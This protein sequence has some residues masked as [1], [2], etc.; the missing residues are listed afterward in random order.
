MLTIGL[1]L[2][3]LSLLIV[4]HELGHFLPAK[5]FGMRVEKFYLFFDWPTRLLRWRRGGTEY[6]IGVLPLGGYVKIAGMVD[7][8][9]L[10]KRGGLPSVPAPDEFR[11]KP[12]HQRA[13]V[14]AGGP[15]MN[16]LFAVALLTALLYTNGTQ[17]VPL[18]R[19]SMGMEALPLVGLQSGDRLLAVNDK[20]AYLDH[21]SSPE[22]LLEEEPV[23]TVLRGQDTLRITLTAFMRDSLM[24]L[25]GQ[26]KEVFVPRLPAQIEPVSGGPAARAGLQKGDLVVSIE[27]EPIQSFSEMRQVLQRLRR[28]TV[29][30]EVRRG[31]KILSVAVQLDTAYRLQAYPAVELP[32]EVTALSLSTAFTLAIFQSYHLTTTNL[33]ALFHLITGRSR[34]SDSV[35]GPIGIAKIAG[36]TFETSGW[37][38]FWAFTA[39]LSLI[40]AIMNLLPIPLLDG[41]HLVFLGLE[42]VFRRE[43][44]YR[45]REIAQYVGLAFIL[46]LMIFAFWNDLRRL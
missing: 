16:I 6:G 22:W 5:L 44:S 36:R 7:E 29:R 26:G 42:A 8:S 39:S 18:H 12:L 32:R 17:R 20:A 43:P 3:A 46:A 33:K 30:L 27:G 40:L 31:E 37:V 15:L 21:I 45:L 23:L 11:A 38:G 25:Y 10:G 35:S 9:Q 13:L 2:L 14:I 1:F 24:S 34:V 41:G 28:D 4:I 19:W